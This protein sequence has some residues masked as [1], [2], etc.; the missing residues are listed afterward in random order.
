[1]NTYVLVHRH[2]ENYTGTAGTAAAWETW[3]KQVGSHLV[4]LGNPV[5]ERTP[6]GT[7][8]TPL[9]LG[10]YTLVTASGL[11]EA[12]ELAKGCPIVDEGGGVEVGLL[13][14]VPGR[15]HP[16]RIF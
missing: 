8:G 13:T 12:V 11:A 5:F 9:P 15:E 14:P 16:A 1:M 4:D 7:C 3:F 10:G 6:V 2:P